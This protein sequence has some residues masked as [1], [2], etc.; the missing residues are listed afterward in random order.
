V[1]AQGL[2]HRSRHV[3]LAIEAPRIAARNEEQRWGVVDDDAADVLGL[4]RGASS[5]LFDFES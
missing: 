3:V 4:R 1:R 2:H 5:M